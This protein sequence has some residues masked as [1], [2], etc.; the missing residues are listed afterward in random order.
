MSLWWGKVQ[1]GHDSLGHSFVPMIG[2]LQW[3]QGSPDPGP[4]SILLLSMW[5]RVTLAQEH[6]PLTDT[7]HLSVL[8]PSQQPFMSQEDTV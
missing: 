5:L 8:L 1:A 4:V 7:H 6:L 2:V 3:P